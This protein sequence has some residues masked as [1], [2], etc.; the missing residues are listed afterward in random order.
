MK[1]ILIISDG[2]P[3]HFN[4]SNG[5]AL[6]INEIHQCT[7]A[8]HEISWRLHLL[9]SAC[10]I[11][12]KL[13]LQLKNKTIA[14]SILWMYSPINLHGY[15]LIIAAG[16]NTMPVSAAIK[17]AFS[18]PVIQLGSPRGLHSSMFN[19]LVTVEKYFEHPSN[20]VAV[21][22]PNLYSPAVCSIAAKK[23]NLSEHILFLIGG[24]GIGYSYNLNEWESMLTQIQALY[25]HTKLPI[26]IVTSRRTSPEIEDLFQSRLQNILSE[27]SAW[28]HHGDKNFNLAALLG[29]A[30]NIFVTED[31]AMMIS[32]SI[33]SGKPVT[34]LYPSTIKSP[35]RYET[36]ISQYADLDLIKR[37][38]IC[39]FELRAPQDLNTRIAEH[40]NELTKKLMRAIKW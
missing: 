33:C 13:L 24:E 21:I 25:S 30:T 8:I 39:S 11:L 23:D 15:D 32:E 10:N 28:F 35:L 4:Q 27:Y 9:G 18:I 29:S 17:L 38:T 26:S 7:I 22:S 34:T 14:R 19:A 20:I 12:A 1:N 31:S 6:M 16:G 5:V 40:R 37:S 2:I 3:G 36:H